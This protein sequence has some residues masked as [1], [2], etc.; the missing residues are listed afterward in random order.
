V[1][2]GPDPG[3]AGLVVGRGQDGLRLLGTDRRPWLRVPKREGT[4]C[5]A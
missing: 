4:L 5:S 2:S 1:K 3:D